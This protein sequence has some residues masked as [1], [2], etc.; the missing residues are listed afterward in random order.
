MITNC[1]SD[2][3]VLQGFVTTNSTG[4][5][6]GPP[7]YSASGKSFSYT[8]SSPHFD[9]E[10]KVF[11]GSYSFVIRTSTARCLYGIADGDISA[12]LTISTSDQGD[13]SQTSTESVSIDSNWLKVNASGFHYSSP[14]LK[15]TLWST[16]TSAMPKLTKAKSVVAKSIATYAKLKMDSTSKFSLKVASGYAKFCKVSGTK[17]KG[18]KI[19]TCKVSVTVTPKKG[20]ALTK[21]VTIKVTK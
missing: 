9:A 3:S 1:F 20:A 15:T 6:A 8:V 19:G 18:L 2:K 11:S 14:V 17:L 13:I 10:N 21:T 7:S 5:S 12:K 4:Y 16:K